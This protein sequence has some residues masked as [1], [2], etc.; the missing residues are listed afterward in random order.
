MESKNFLR[1]ALLCLAGIALPVL[2]ATGELPLGA[3]VEGLLDYAR[4]NPE[5]AAMRYEAEAATQRVYP[6]GAFP[7]PLFRMELQN[8]TN[9]GSD[10]SPSLVPSKVGST[11]YTLV[12]PIP[13]WGKRD[14]KR[15][16]AEADAE[17]AQGRV[18][19][20]WSELAANV[21]TA[22]ARYYLVVHN[23]QLTREILD[24]LTRLERIA[25]VRYESG[26]VP[27]Q[28]VI[29]SQ[30][31][32]TT[33]RGELLMQESERAG[34]QAMLNSL[35]ARK[36]AAPLAAPE[37]LRAVPPP[38][39]LDEDELVDRLRGHNPQLFASNARIRAA[40]KTRELTYRNR[41]PDFAVGVSPIQMGSR[42]G[43][44]EL[45]VEVNIPLQQESRR[46]QESEAESML[47]AAR[48]QKEAAAN[49]LIGELFENL[50]ALKAA[51][52]IELLTTTSILPQS[53]ATLEAA[54][55]G[56][57][58][59]KVDFA[60]LLDAQRQIRKSK[61]DRLKAQAEA[62]AR[63]AAIERLLGEDL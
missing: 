57:E 2:G 40:E 37:R 46:R 17:Q 45:M 42:I 19:A 6:A 18:A 54:L 28:D 39:R 7:D 30:V 50:A 13:F 10:A 12:Q 36:A 14:L 44:W 43:E 4:A 20:T 31:E 47:S 62:Q 8:I 29:R 1:L 61:Q 3:N 5:Y 58:T 41:Y 51:Q 35:L 53:E 15:E 59:G 26:L 27:Q 23:E 32:R 63:L 21:K 33:M 16:V 55:A 34:V 60:T 24:L 9:A 25:L 48:S 56:Y 52:R 22:Y 49:R 38:V 11:K